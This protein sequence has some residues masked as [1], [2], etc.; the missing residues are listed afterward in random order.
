[1]MF[2]KRLPTISENDFVR[3]EKPNPQTGQVNVYCFKCL[4]LARIE[5]VLALRRVS[6]DKINELVDLFK[7]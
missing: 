6:E 4:V 5:P 1:M 3:I 2:L 7:L